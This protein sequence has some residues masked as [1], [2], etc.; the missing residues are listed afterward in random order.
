MSPENGWHFNF[1]ILIL[2]LYNEEII[3]SK[4]TKW[5]NVYFSKEEI[6]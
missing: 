3:K 4:E 5:L 6:K 2:N 1:L